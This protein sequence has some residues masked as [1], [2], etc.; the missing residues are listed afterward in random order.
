MKLQEEI[1]SQ[2]KI[3]EDRISQIESRHSI[4]IKGFSEKFIGVT[5][6]NEKLMGQLAQMG[7]LES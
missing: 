5:S 1:M 4:E 3:Y 2:K 7:R 6:V